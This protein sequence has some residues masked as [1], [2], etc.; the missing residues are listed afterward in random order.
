MN[1]QNTPSTDISFIS[2]NYKQ[3]CV[4]MQNIYIYIFRN[5]Y[6]QK[7]K[8]LINYMSRNHKLMGGQFGYFS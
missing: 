2:D 8:I 1:K 5:G 6:M 3:L 4:T 7:Q